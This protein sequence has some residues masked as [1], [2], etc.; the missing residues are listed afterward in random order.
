[1]RS[2]K[3]GV[4]IV[5]LGL[6]VFAFSGCGGS[7]DTDSD[8]DSSTPN[9]LPDTYDTAE[10]LS[11]AWEYIGEETST[12]EI[13]SDDTYTLS[14]TLAGASLVITDV[15]VN[16]TSGTARITLHE[17]WRAFVDGDTTTYYGIIPVNIDAQTMSLTKTAKDNWRCDVYE[18]YRST[19]NI[20]ILA[21]DIIQL[22][23]NRV[24]DVGFLK[25]K[26][27]ENIMSFRKP[28]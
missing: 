12:V 4:V 28:Q 6:C 16:N 25:A 18:P 8:S 14:M 1:M 13:D 22:T 5:M 27:Y 3:F 10:L 11:G 26:Q 9:S 20:E 19:I 23:E 21:E 24:A 15:N 2:M 17:T 7:A